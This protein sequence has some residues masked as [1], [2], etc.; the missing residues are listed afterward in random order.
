V[1]EHSFIVLPFNEAIF[2]YEEYKIIIICHVNDLIITGPDETKITDIVNKLSNKLKLEY[3][4]LINQFLRIEINLDYKNKAILIYQT[5]YLNNI[6]KRFNK[7]NL[8]PVLTLIELRVQL[9]KAEDKAN[10]EDLTLY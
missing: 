2:I 3:I 6:I 4:R 7:D 1:K 8:T 9:Y 10:K 5:K